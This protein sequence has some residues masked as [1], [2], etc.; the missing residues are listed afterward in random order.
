MK[1]TNVLII[2]LALLILGAEPGISLQPQAEILN[3]ASKFCINNGG[4]SVLY[5]GSDTGQF[6]VCY[7]NRQ[8]CCEEWTMYRNNQTCPK[9]GIPLPVL[10]RPS[11]V[12]EKYNCIQSVV[13]RPDSAFRPTINSAILQGKFFI[14]FSTFLIIQPTKFLG[15]LHS[16]YCTC[17]F[18]GTH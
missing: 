14:N 18:G 16:L 13:I 5:T 9:Y 11:M 6:G 8:R 15:L 10:S 4:K 3:P 1:F 2:L 17:K 7:F 12:F